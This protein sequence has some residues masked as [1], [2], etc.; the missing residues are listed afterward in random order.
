MVRCG[1]S[2]RRG[3]IWPTFAIAVDHAE[4]AEVHR[5]LGGLL[6]MAPHLVAADHPGRPPRHVKRRDL[7]RRSRS[8]RVGPGDDHASHLTNRPSVQ[9]GP[10]GQG[11]AIGGRH[12]L[13][14]IVIA[15]AVERALDHL[16]HHPPAE[17]DMGS[18]VGDNE[19]QRPSPCRTRS[20]RRSAPC[21]AGDAAT[22]L[23]IAVPGTGPGRTTRRPD[24]EAQR[25]RLHGKRAPFGTVK[26][27]VAVEATGPVVRDR[28]EGSGV[29]DDRGGSGSRSTP[30]GGGGRSR[31]R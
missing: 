8:R 16:A 17:S 1:P 23:P 28:L 30:G 7:P 27:P 3:A 10:T 24:G 5:V 4:V 22:G 6:G 12:A 13:P 29:P 21:R 11:T 20:G 2:T 14:L 15:K 19:R 18:Q 31:G 9:D 25:P 26:I